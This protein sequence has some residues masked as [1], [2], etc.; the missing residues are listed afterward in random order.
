[1]SPI[2]GRRGPAS[3][4]Q[5][6]G[7]LDVGISQGHCKTSRPIQECDGEVIGCLNILTLTYTTGRQQHFSRRS[8]TSSHEHFHYK[9]L[10]IEH[11]TQHTR[12]NVAKKVQKS[13][14]WIIKGL[15]STKLMSQMCL[16]SHAQT[17]LNQ[18]TKTRFR[19]SVRAA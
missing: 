4:L 1:M 11:T 12:S 9:A 10:E 3:V 8:R 2:F 15:E 16:Q 7:W 13:R 5:R 17:H 14:I 19:I 18:T 6:A